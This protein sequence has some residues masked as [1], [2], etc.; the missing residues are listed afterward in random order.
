MKQR[1]DG[2]GSR[3]NRDD[4]VLAGEEAV[5]AG[6]TPACLVRCREPLEG[7]AGAQS[8]GAFS[9]PGMVS[10]LGRLAARIKRR[11]WRPARPN[12]PSASPRANATA[13][14]AIRLATPN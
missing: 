8:Q 2:E 9:V 14:A 5:R 4:R 3:A 7:R 13:S 12:R 6:A 10:R 11:A 1:R